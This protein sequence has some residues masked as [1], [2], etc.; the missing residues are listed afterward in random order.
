LTSA[1]FLVSSTVM[2]TCSS[3]AKCS[4]FCLP[5]ICSSYDE[6]P[7]WQDR[8]QTVSNTRVLTLALSRIE[9]FPLTIILHPVSCS[10]CLAV[11]PRGPNIRPTKLNLNNKLSV[12]MIRSLLGL[13]CKSS[14]LLGGLL[15][16]R[17]IFRLTALLVQRV[18]AGI[19]TL[20]RRVGI[21]LHERDLFLDKRKIN[22][23]KNRH[24]SQQIDRPNNRMHE[25]RW[26][27]LAWRL[28]V[29]YFVNYYKVFT[30]N[31]KRW[32]RMKSRKGTG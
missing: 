6:K 15:P 7:W 22:R 31:Y 13:K 17:I 9:P 30:C 3:S 2:S 11:I 24:K 1:R 8:L 4:Q 21:N 20:S 12:K 23:V 14:L 25:W 26:N 5:F 16:V 29:S 19:S 18:R 28:L 32:G 10:N 27:K